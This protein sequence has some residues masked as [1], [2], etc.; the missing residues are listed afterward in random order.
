MVASR[1]A[2]ILRSVRPATL[3]S[4]AY[5]TVAPVLS[6]PVNGFVGAIGNTPLVGRLCSRL[7]ELVY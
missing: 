7:T 4:R 3:S 5:A 1:S 6:K 2:S